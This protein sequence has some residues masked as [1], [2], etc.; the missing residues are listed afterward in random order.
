MHSCSVANTEAPHGT[1]VT[2]G[3]AG[4]CQEWWLC[5]A[6]HLVFEGI[7][8]CHHRA[9]HHCMTNGAAVE[10]LLNL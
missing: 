3:L 4:R 6:V 9:C 7:I 1:A 10:A 8:T 2:L 5:L